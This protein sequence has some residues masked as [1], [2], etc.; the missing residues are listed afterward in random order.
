M[1][2]ATLSEVVATGGLTAITNATYIGLRPEVS[3]LVRFMDQAPFSSR[4]FLEPRA[5]RP[6][7][8]CEPAF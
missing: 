1:R 8:N 6:P 4:R 3:A 2:D 5:E 7:E